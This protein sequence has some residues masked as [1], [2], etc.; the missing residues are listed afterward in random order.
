MTNRYVIVG[1]GAIGGGIGGLLARAGIPTVL[2]ARGAHLDRL[3][4]AGLRVRTP[5][6]D[7]TTAVTVAGSPADVVL[8]DDDVLVFAT[9]THQIE[10]ALAEWADAPVGDRTAGEALPALIALNGVEAEHRAQRWFARVYGVCVWMPATFLTPG[11]VLVGGTPLRG[12][13]HTSRVPAA[14]A[15]DDDRALLGAVAADWGRAGFEVPLPDDVLPWKYRKLLNNL[16]N[17]NQAL[18]GTVDGD[19]ARAVRDEAETIYAA[20]GIGINSEEEEQ[21]SRARLQVQPVPGA[22]EQLGGSTW[23]SLARGAGTT[24]VDFLNGEIVTLAHGLGL[25]APVNGG[26]ARAMRRASAEGTGPGA[27]TAAELAA[28]LG[29]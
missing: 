9:K 25:R 29:L 1:A 17:A 15:D 8:T 26:L 16:V 27:I 23:Q 21:A 19:I 5:D 13:L 7:F 22:P 12:I 18:L 3:R 24:E 28:A 10:A 6:L 2:V 11:E 14:L 4:D 20:A